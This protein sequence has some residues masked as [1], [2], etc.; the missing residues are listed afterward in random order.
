MWSGQA[1]DHT[2]PILMSYPLGCCDWARDWHVTHRSLS[3]T[4]P[5]IVLLGLGGKNLGDG[6]RKM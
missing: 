3:E 5:R 2:E 4:A 1:H 6:F